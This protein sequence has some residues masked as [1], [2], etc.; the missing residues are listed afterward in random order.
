MTTVC[1]SPVSAKGLLYDTSFHSLSEHCEASAGVRS[2]LLVFLVRGLGGAPARGYACFYLMKMSRHMGC[3]ILDDDFLLAFSSLL[4][5]RRSTIVRRTSRRGHNIDNPIEF[6]SI[7]LIIACLW[8]RE[9]V[10]SY[11]V[12]GSLERFHA[13]VSA[14]CSSSHQKFQRVTRVQT[15]CAACFLPAIG[16]SDGRLLVALAI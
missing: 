13:L 8:T 15:S 7:S 5:L 14:I 9:A 10:G 6:G 2:S 1:I 12:I 4:V 3:F 11:G 16:C